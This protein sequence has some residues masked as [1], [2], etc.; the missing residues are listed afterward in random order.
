MYIKVSFQVVNL[1]KKI[2]PKNMETQ[3][4]YSTALDLEVG[5]WGMDR[6]GILWKLCQSPGWPLLDYGLLATP[7]RESERVLQGPISQS[8]SL[9]NC[10][11]AF[12]PGFI[13]GYVPAVH[14]NM[15]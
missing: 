9:Q 2:S 11:G 13:T 6:G 15:F 4:G 8:P 14:L 7:I 1:N 12:L 5:G 10:S 3:K